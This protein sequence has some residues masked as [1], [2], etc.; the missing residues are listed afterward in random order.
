MRFTALREAFGPA[1]ARHDQDV[2][3][4]EKIFLLNSLGKRR[5]KYVVIANLF[6]KRRTTMVKDKTIKSVIC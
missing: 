4:K 6:I 3:T 5:R 1:V 2:S